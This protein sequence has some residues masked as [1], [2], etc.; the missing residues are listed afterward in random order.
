MIDCDMARTMRS[1][2]SVGPGIW[3]NGRPDIEAP[4][5]AEVIVRFILA[6]SLSPG[7]LV[8][9]RQRRRG[10]LGLTVEGPHLGAAEERRRADGLVHEVRDGQ[11]VREDRQRSEEH[12]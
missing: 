6:R 1:G 11:L 3:R 2:T 10:D 9:R 7:A 4:S 12:T 5:N 8:T